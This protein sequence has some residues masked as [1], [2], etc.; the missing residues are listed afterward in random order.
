VE[1]PLS[2]YQ[3]WKCND[4]VKSYADLAAPRVEPRLAEIYRKFSHKLTEYKDEMQQNFNVDPNQKFDPKYVGERIDKQ[5][6]LAEFKAF[7]TAE[8]DA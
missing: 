4:K 2:F 1:L 8:I 6:D 3:K 7:H 5:K